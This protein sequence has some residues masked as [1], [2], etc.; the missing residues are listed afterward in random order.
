M[1]EERIVKAEYVV[2]F[3]SKKTGKFVRAKKVWVKRE[4]QP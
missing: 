2:R 1:S 3:R 4:K